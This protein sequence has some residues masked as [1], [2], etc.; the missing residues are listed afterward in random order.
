MGSSSTDWST[1]AGVITSIAFGAVPGSMPQI[2]LT[3]P[4]DAHSP[5]WNGCG[6]GWNP[7]AWSGLNPS[8]PCSDDGER[9]ARAGRAER[10]ERHEHRDV[11]RG[12]AGRH[13]HG[14]ERLPGGVDEDR[15]G[16]ALDLD[17]AAPRR[18]VGDRVVAARERRSGGG[19]G[20]AGVVHEDVDQLRTQGR[21]RT[22]GT[23]PG[24]A[25]AARRCR[26]RRSPGT[27]RCRTRR[28]GSCRT[29]GRRRCRARCRPRSGRSTSST[30]VPVMKSETTVRRAY[31]VAPPAVVT[32]TV[33]TEVP[34]GAGTVAEKAP[35]ASA[36]H[37]DH[38]WWRP[39]RRWRWRRRPPWRLAWWSP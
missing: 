38:A 21:S 13:R 29:S 1:P 8:W 30:V 9:P 26:R 12:L 11:A 28:R 6:V 10:G 14:A 17:P 27:A 4:G 33:I 34:N 35:P 19:R 18:A 39:R 36:V 16:E 25:G 5:N 2:G 7:R 37:R 15:A 31:P 32:A 23:G 20:G 22:W 3:T 24:C